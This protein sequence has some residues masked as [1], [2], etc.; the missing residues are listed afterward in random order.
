MHASEAAPLVITTDRAAIDRVYR[1]L[2]I[3][4]VVPVV[5][6]S[7]V[8]VGAGVLVGQSLASPT[9]AAVGIAVGMA[10][11]SIVLVVLVAAFLALTAYQWGVLRSIGERVV[12]D[13]SGM[14]MQLPVGR[15]QVPWSAVHGARITGAGRSEVLRLD[16]DASALVGDLSHRH[17]RIVASKGLAFGA[18]GMQP[19]I[20]ALANAVAAGTAGRVVPQRR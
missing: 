2:V 4:M 17:R 14:R 15:V 20:A 16:V 7:L 19:G 1:P 9:G 13:G 12:A 18:V 6:V 11:L 5:L 10:A 3:V 8:V